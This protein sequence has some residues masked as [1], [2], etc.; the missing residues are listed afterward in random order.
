MPK[1]SRRSRK[2]Q[3]TIETLRQ[4]AARVGNRER[5]TGGRKIRQHINPRSVP[6]VILVLE[7]V[8]SARDRA[9][10]EDHRGIQ[11]RDRLKNWSRRGPFHENEEGIGGAEGRM[12]SEERRGGEEGRFRWSPYHSK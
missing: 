3:H 5:R 7:A 11:E 8:G 4:L 10:G 6:E 2:H 9:P 1:K 12:R